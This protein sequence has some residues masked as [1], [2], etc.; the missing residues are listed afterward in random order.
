MAGSLGVLDIERVVI[1]AVRAALQGVA[2]PVQSTSAT[3][4][5]PA[6]PSASGTSNFATT[7][8]SLRS[9]E[10]TLISKEDIEGLLLLGTTLSE[11]ASILRIS[12]P[13]L[14]K[15][16]RETGPQFSFLHWTDIFCY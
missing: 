10:H 12:R 3:V 16:M 9:G 11:V 4:S 8:T 6:V 7:V 2:P 1:A 15:L 5:T 13:T 14:Y